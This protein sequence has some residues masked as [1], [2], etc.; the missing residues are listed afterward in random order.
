MRPSLEV[1]IALV[2]QLILPTLVEL[3]HHVPDIVGQGL[4]HDVFDHSLLE[5]VGYDGKRFRLGRC[6]N[7]L[8]EVVSESVL[9][10]GVFKENRLWS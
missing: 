2:L 4:I 8:Q 10:A 6:R 5:I 1:L 3:D 7:L 9:E